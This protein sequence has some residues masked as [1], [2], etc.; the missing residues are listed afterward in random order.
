MAALGFDVSEEASARVRDLAALLELV[1]FTV[2]FDVQT[3]FYRVR[4]AASPERAAELAPLAE[5]LGFVA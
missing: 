1:G 5:R 2:P 4:A 3:V